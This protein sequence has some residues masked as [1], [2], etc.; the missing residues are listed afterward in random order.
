M[1]LPQS[2]NTKGAELNP[3]LIVTSSKHT[4]CT[5][6]RICLLSIYQP[7]YLWMSNHLKRFFFS[8]FV[9]YMLSWYNFF[10]NLLCRARDINVYC[11]L[12]CCIMID[13]LLLFLCS[14]FILY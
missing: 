2:N 12:L 4:T 11:L 9:F 13:I 8:F 3:L 10:S 14:S 7:F 1:S 5:V 6:V